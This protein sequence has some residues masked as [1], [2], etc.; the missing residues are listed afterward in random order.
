MAHVAAAGAVISVASLASGIITNAVTLAN[1]AADIKERKIQFCQSVVE[2]FNNK[3]FNATVI[4][5]KHSAA[6]YE[7][8][9]NKQF[10]GSTYWIYTVPQAGGTMAVENLGDGGWENWCNGGIN[11]IR[12]GNVNHF[13]GH[14]D[15]GMGGACEK[16]NAA[17]YPHRQWFDSTKKTTYGDYF[18][19]V[20]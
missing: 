19:H 7:F 10:E 9:T 5:S 20:A 14:W 13:H 11:W 17:D 12:W 18:G 6:G 15:D 1:R 4:C 16:R 2:G 3:G 8:H